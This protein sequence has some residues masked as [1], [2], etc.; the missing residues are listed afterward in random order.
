MNGFDTD[1]LPLNVMGSGMI[2]LVMTISMD[3]LTAGCFIQYLMMFIPIH[4]ILLSTAVLAA[5]ANN[6]ITLK[7]NCHKTLSELVSRGCI[8]VLFIR[9]INCRYLK[10][11]L[12]PL[13]TH[14][15]IVDVTGRG[16][17]SEHRVEV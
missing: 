7:S 6:T 1:A 13:V 3:L 5:A 4:N 15:N 8:H 10:L 11:V 12:L 14:L 9:K 17:Y 2:V 16:G